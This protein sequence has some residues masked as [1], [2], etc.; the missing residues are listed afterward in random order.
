MPSSFACP[1]CSAPLDYEG[2]EPTH[3]CPYC[4]SSVIVPDSLRS[5]R[6]DPLNAPHVGGG[7]PWVGSALLSPAERL[8]EIGL[9]IRAGNKAEAIR[10]YRETFNVGLAQAK[11]A[12]DALAA[13]RPVLMPGDALPGDSAAPP[14]SD[15]PI[16]AAFTPQTMAASSRGVTYAINSGPSTQRTPFLVYWIG[17]SL[18]LLLPAGLLTLT[19]LPFPNLF[20]L[21]APVLCPAH[22]LDAFGQLHASRDSGDKS[23]SYNVS[24]T[25]VDAEGQNKPAN[26]LA[27][28]AVVFG[29]S[30][31]AE[32][33][34]A[35]GLAALLRFRLAGCLPLLVILGVLPAAF[36]AYAGTIPAG[37]ADPL[38]KL[39]ESPA[40]RALAGAAGLP[41]GEAA[42]T[43]T[44][45]P[46]GAPAFA[47]LITSF[48]GGSGTDAGQFNDTRMVAVDGAGNIYTA[49]YSGGRIQAF[50]PDGQFA[51]QWTIKG[52]TLYITG[53]SAGP[54][55]L[56]Y[57]LFGGKVNK[58]DGA[59]GSF[60]GKL[61][62]NGSFLQLAAP[63]PDGGL[64]AVSSQ[65]IVHFD[66]NGQQTQEVKNWA[67]KIGAGGSPGADDVAVD[68]AGNIYLVDGSANAIYQFTAAG[69]FAGTVGAAGKDPGQLD[70]PRAIAFDAQGRMYVHDYKGIQVFDP[71]GEYL[72]LIPVD[73]L[74][75]DMAITAEGRLVFMDRNANKVFVYQLPH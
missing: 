63:A 70:D 36:L 49:D 8:R 27:A 75:F 41:G 12:V 68:G 50:K 60:Q 52:D 7:T 25:C 5:A 31:G 42:A 39:I 58:Y 9:Q 55:G 28:W 19:A 45:G 62:Y 37:G 38:L 4:N 17:L 15:P 3:R 66:A 64:V 74:G 44:A 18:A 35:F 1:N 67:R 21:A 51:G 69:D 13:G 2:D 46:A 71:S 32:I 48:G 59:T 24:L 6:S 23:T 73:G 40:A 61:A 53:L 30:I 65:S 34:V 29:G 20:R 14:S 57:V 16:T 47:R 33:L 72:A 54:S 43:A 56:M 22:Y 26:G 10:I 11:E